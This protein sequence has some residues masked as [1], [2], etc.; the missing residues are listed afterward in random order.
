M[1]NG[2]WNIAI[3]TKFSIRAFQELLD[4]ITK[5]ILSNK[6]NLPTIAQYTQA[7]LDPA[8][9]YDREFH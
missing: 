7:S 1:E 8:K 9:Y 3:L 4:I 2:I 6:V 5:R